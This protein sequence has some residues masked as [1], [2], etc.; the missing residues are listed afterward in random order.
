MWKPGI[1]GQS[2]TDDELLF[3]N[4]SRTLAINK[5]YGRVADDPLGA[6]RNRDFPEPD[7]QTMTPSSV[8]R[9]G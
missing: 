1:P 8:S 2:R 7:F 6:E 3:H 9:L 4:A 5:N